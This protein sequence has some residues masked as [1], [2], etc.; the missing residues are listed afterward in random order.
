M[1]NGPVSA[2]ISFL[3]A[4][5]FQAGCVVLLPALMGK[6]GIWLAV[7]AAELAALSVT[8]LC[9]VLNRKQYRYY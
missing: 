3:R 5:L 7:V 2:L 4:F 9:F 6:D 1:N 8:A